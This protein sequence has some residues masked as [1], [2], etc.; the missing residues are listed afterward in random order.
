LKD[1]PVHELKI[2][3]SFVKD[4]LEQPRN[5]AIVQSTVDLA[6][7]LGMRV[8]AEGVEDRGTW[9]LLG[10]VG[11]DMAQGYFLSRPVSGERILDWRASAQVAA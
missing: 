1:L 8:V 10:R 6:H 7:H 5:R 4:M 3:R 11:C 9:E 2:D